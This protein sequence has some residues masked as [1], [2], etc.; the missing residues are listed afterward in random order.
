[1]ET[2]VAGP[3]TRQFTDENFETEV[4]AADRPVLVDFST[5][6]CAPCRLLAPVIDEVAG[7]FVGRAIVGK[8]DTDTS[9]Q[10]TARFS[11]HGVPTVVLFRNGQEIHRFAGPKPIAE[12]RRLLE[13]ALA[14]A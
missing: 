6:W 9:P 13:A 4:G 11:V 14:T 2:Q 5:E 3:H 10:T 8:V 12:V 1:M 7:E